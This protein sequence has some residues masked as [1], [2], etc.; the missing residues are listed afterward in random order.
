MLRAFRAWKKTLE[1]EPGIVP[2]LGSF[3]PYSRLQRTIVNFAQ[4]WVP[5]SFERVELIFAISMCVASVYPSHESLTP[6]PISVWG[7]PGSPAA[8]LSSKRKREASWRRSSRWREG[9]A[10]SFWHSGRPAVSMLN[11]FTVLAMSV[12]NYFWFSRLNIP[13]GNQKRKCCERVNA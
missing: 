13:G 7:P 10:V 1:L 9:R 8:S 4:H 3:H 12:L 5:I 2:S 11:E 6:L